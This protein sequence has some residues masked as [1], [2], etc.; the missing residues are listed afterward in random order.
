MFLLVFGT[1]PEYIKIKPLI[2]VFNENNFKNYKLLFTG[3]HKT[4]IEENIYADYKLEIFEGENR[5][6]NIFISIL[7]R[8][9][10]FKDIKK[11][12]VQGDTATAYAVALSAFHMKIPVIHLE[13]GLRTY[14][15]ENPY[16]EEFYRRCISNLSSINFCV[17]DIGIKNL[18]KEKV[19]GKNYIVGNTVL[20]NLKNIEVS[21]QN[22]ILV[23]LHR[24]ENQ[25]IIDK[26]FFELEKISNKYKNYEFLIPIHPNPNILKYKNILKN[27]KVVDPLTHSALLD[28]LSKVK[29][30]ITDS[31]GLQ[32]E[33]SFLKKKSIVCRKTT[34]R[35]E[36]LGTFSYLCKKPKNLYKF[37][38]S[39]MTSFEI[40][41]PCPYGDGNA[42]KKIYDILVNT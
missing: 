16:P 3:Q 37:V 2:K 29:F 17:S 40:N 22:K 19:P 36:G 33:S 30:I 35:Q 6:N 18:V 12:I 10:I 8:V 1:R 41:E 20:D 39:L 34:E 5:L 26:W 32:E 9:D 23:T 38:D 13:A 14:D 11:V 21:Y 7:S 28:Y 27:V 42:S 24:R 4:L 31:G 25:E 15:I